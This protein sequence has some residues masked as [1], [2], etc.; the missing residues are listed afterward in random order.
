MKGMIVFDEGGISLASVGL[1]SIKLNHD[2]F[3]SFISA[4]Q[5]YAQKSVGS[6]MKSL[7]YSKMKLMI[8]HA[9][10]N[11][12]VTLH[13]IDDPDAAW[14]HSA[15]VKVIEGDGFKLN[16]QYLDILRS[17]LTDEIITPDE[18]ENGIDKLKTASRSFLDK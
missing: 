6:E 1:E 15:T 12:V 4:I 17:L 14:N 10:D 13:S 3:G 8:D 11:F 18:V 7:T 9:A 16:D 2:L 5:A